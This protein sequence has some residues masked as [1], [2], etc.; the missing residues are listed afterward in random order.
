MSE[1][2][3]LMRYRIGSVVLAGVYKGNGMAFMRRLFT[4]RQFTASVR[5]FR[6]PDPRGGHHAGTKG[7]Y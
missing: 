1:M 2:M 6:P 5:Y 4:V 7:H 3:N